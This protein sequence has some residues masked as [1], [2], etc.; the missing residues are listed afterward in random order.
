[1]AETIGPVPVELE[2]TIGPITLGTKDIVT[3]IIPVE[4]KTAI[5]SHL[6]HSS[7]GRVRSPLASVAFVSREFASASRPFLFSKTVVIAAS[8]MCQLANLLCSPHRTIPAQV[9][10]LSLSLNPYEWRAYTDPHSPWNEMRPFIRGRLWR[11]INTILK[12]LHPRDQLII[13]LPLLFEREMEWGLVGGVNRQGLTE[14][15]LNGSFTSLQSATEALS[16][17]PNLLVLVVEATWLHDFIPQGGKL[18][19]KLKLLSIHSRSYPLLAWILDLSESLVNLET[20]RTALFDCHSRDRLP[21][22]ER[23]LGHYGPNLKN[24]CLWFSEEQAVEEFQPLMQHVPNLIDIGLLYPCIHPSDEA[25]AREW[26]DRFRAHV[27]HAHSRFMLGR[28]VRG[29]MLMAYP[30]YSGELKE[31]EYEWIPCDCGPSGGSLELG[32]SDS[33]IDDG[34]HSEEGSLGTGEVLGGPQDSEGVGGAGGGFPGRRLAEGDSKGGLRGSVEYEDGHDDDDGKDDEVPKGGDEEYEE[35]AE[36][37]WDCGKEHV[38]GDLNNRESYENQEEDD[39]EDEDGEYMASGLTFPFPLNQLPD[40]Q[41]L[42]AWHNTI[43]IPDNR[44]T[45]PAR[46]W[47]HFYARR[48]RDDV[49]ITPLDEW[50]PRG[51]LDSSITPQAYPYLDLLFTDDASGFESE[52]GDSA[53]TQRHTHEEREDVTS[54]SSQN[55]RRH[56]WSQIQG[57]A[58]GIG[59]N[60]PLEA[61]PRAGQR[62]TSSRSHQEGGSGG[63]K[64]VDSPSRGDSVTVTVRRGSDNVTVDLGTAQAVAVHVHA[65]LTVTIRNVHRVGCP[66]VVCVLVAMNIL[67]SLSLLIYLYFT[68]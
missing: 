43:L 33:I 44:R 46:H 56:T 35:D 40:M 48:F 57:E 8:R 27:P 21:L 38:E 29:S 9:H 51:P 15:Y 52:E 4:I 28:Y 22:L 42:H 58:G 18:S 50:T 1:M 31:G 37:D 12:E 45:G 66:L 13:Q 53:I 26:N 55:H 64:R 10:T 36:G 17:M 39:E 2:E 54:D 62:S 59:Y 5:V 25:I 63:R 60:D 24:L 19:S 7:S 16:H 23:F 67:F 20:F 30:F 14:L 65:D 68:V 6:P 41:R 49:D 61:D 3:P 47:G 32:S 11:W 34:Q